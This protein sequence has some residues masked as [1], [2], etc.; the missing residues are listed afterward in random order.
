MKSEPNKQSKRA[1]LSGTLFFHGALLLILFLIKLVSPPLPD[2]EE[3]I[4]INFGN[5]EQGMGEIQPTQ[6]SNANSPQEANADQLKE[7]EVSNPTPVKP[8]PNVTQDVEEAPKIS[9]DKPKVKPVET[10]KPVTKPVV[11]PK[12]PEDPKPDPRALYPGKKNT[13]GKGTPGNEGETGRPGDQGRPD[14]SMDSKSHTGTGKGDSGISFDL[15]GRNMLRKPTINDQSQEF[16][17]VIIEV[18]VDKDG[19]VTQVTG[20]A[21]GSTTSAPILVNK[22]KQAAREAKFS[23]SPSGVEEQRGTITFVFSP[24]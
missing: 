13:D 18:T 1:G 15:A 7:P 23:K 11:Q 14:G 19:N 9:K 3:G 10:T 21:R 4:L 6:I 12:P 8:Q 22:A 24:Q 16:G 17:K 20:P 5:S 2:E